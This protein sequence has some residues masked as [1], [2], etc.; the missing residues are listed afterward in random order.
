MSVSL[1]IGGQWGDEGKA[2]IIDYLARD[3][4]Y[5]VR[6]QGGANAGH[7][8]VVDGKRFAF[9]LLPSGLLY[10]KVTCLLGG[11]MVIDP[12]ALSKEID[13][14]VAEGIEV[15]GRIL[16]SEQAHL[17]LPYHV[18]VDG[19]SEAKLGARSIGTT[20]K[21]I[22]PAY[23]DKA[24][25]RGVR[26]GDFLRSRSEL[27]QLLTQK[28]REG[29]KALRQLGASPLP[30]GKTVAELLRV[31]KRLEPMITDT[32]LTLWSALDKKKDILL[33]GAQGSLLD[34]D[35]GTFPY[36]TSSNPTVGGA[37][38]GTGLPAHALGRVIGIFKAYCTRVGNGPFPTEDVRK[39]GD[40]I[41]K[42]GGEY[43]TTTGRARRCGWFDA[44]AARTVVRLNGITDV[45]LTKLDVLDTFDDI[46]VCTSYRCGKKRLEYFPNDVR[47]LERCKPHYEVMPG[48]KETTNR[49]DRA[50]LPAK[51]AAYVGF[52]EELIGC[53]IDLV[54]LGPDRNAMIRFSSRRDRGGSG[55]PL[56]GDLPG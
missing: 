14:V 19:A 17:V 52:L 12:I 35:H 41:R 20:R 33:E 9:H 8:V 2:K 48:W 10:P 28:I 26:V 29:N 50:E 31:K 7:T 25:R 4:D 42:L 1:I 43:G 6:Y 24:S 56:T 51:A 34:I 16:I 30:V 38:V 53:R 13:G 5:V 37:I 55:V 39:K 23:T 40:Q 36:V 54:S 21:G 15:K 45:A 32:R 49:A 22:A 27:E 3:A 11:G 47:A 46:K 44:V 18:L